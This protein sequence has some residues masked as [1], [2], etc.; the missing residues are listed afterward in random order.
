MIVLGFHRLKHIFANMV[1]QCFG[2][3]C[4]VSQFI[5]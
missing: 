2:I 5:V 1:S 3:F 4:K